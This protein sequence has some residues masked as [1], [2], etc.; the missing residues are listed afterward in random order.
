MY[1]FDPSNIYKNHHVVISS[2]QIS[3]KQIFVSKRTNIRSIILNEY[4]NIRY[5]R[6]SPKFNTVPLNTVKSKLLM[7]V[8]GIQL[9]H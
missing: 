7:I 2:K 4:S 6:F 1:I 9:Y 5:I 8:S 3:S